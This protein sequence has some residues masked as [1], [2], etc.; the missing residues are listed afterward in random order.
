MLQPPPSAAYSAT[1]SSLTQHTPD[2][3]VPRS[4]SSASSG[5][6]PALT[7]SQQR[8]AHRVRYA[9]A[10]STSAAGEVA[11][12]APHCSAR[13]ANRA[14]RLG[15]C[16]GSTDSVPRTP[17]RRSSGTLIGILGYLRPAHRNPGIPRTCP[18]VKTPANHQPNKSNTPLRKSHP[19][20][21]LSSPSQNHPA[22]C[23]TPACR[24]SP[25]NA[26]I[27]GQLTET[28]TIRKEDGKGDAT[29]LH[30]RNPAVSQSADS[31]STADSAARHTV[32]LRRLCS[33][34]H[35]TVPPP[36]DPEHSASCTMLH[37]AAPA[38][39]CSTSL[40]LKGQPAPPS[41]AADPPTPAAPVQ[42]ARSCWPAVP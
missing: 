15:W 24:Q 30:G 25:K 40:T 32:Q 16:N 20:V 7:C 42:T 1:H 3:G 39:A 33:R 23:R 11:N 2:G 17:I 6:S 12:R 27:G 4:L 8:E 38:L 21:R 19:G 13:T 9:A 26:Q 36:I 28:G 29:T 41:P 14:L 31:P 37:N 35:S 18:T 34:L 22:E 10:H 5:T